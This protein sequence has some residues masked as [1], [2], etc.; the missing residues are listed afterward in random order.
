MDFTNKTNHSIEAW[1]WW[2][3]NKIEGKDNMPS[4]LWYNNLNIVDINNE[5]G[6]TLIMQYPKH[7][8]IE[9]INKIN[10]K[11]NLSVF[12]NEG[13]L[14][15]VKTGI[16]E[17]NID[18]SPEFLEAL[19]LKEQTN[20]DYITLTD[21]IRWSKVTFEN[22]LNDD[23][24]SSLFDPRLGEWMALEIVRQVA[25]E[26]N[27]K[28]DKV[29]IFSLDAA[30]KYAYAIHPNN[31]ILNKKLVAPKKLTWENIS[32]LMENYQVKFVS[33]DKLI[34]DKRF[35]PTFNWSFDNEEM[36]ESIL[37]ALGS[38]LVCL[39]SKQIDLP[40]KW[41]PVGHQFIWLNLANKM[42]KNTPVS[43]YTRDIILGCFSKRNIETKRLVIDRASSKFKFKAEDDFKNDPPRFVD[44]KDFIKYLK[45][46]QE[47][48]KNQQIS[49]SEH[50]P[51]Q[52]IPIS[53]IQMKNVQ[54]Q[55][56]IDE[57]K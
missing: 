35:S 24:K 52:L 23:N 8:P 18:H 48:L 11:R 29:D 2:I 1:L 14:F 21:W 49:V 6:Q 42:L 12:Q 9:I 3:S 31:F 34:K 43:S 46:S 57:I 4:E 55:E 53:L 15:D 39:L 26:M 41:N 5:I 38:L 13:W 7:I 40:S 27:E 54:Y 10:Q 22:A 36:V 32:G 33:D 50:Q 47:K 44:I 37:N 17:R 25:I 19:K 45:L 30:N 56:L 20:Q 16:R 51:R 28:I